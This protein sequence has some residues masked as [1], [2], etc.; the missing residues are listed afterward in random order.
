MMADYLMPVVWSTS[1]GR[2]FEDVQG[3]D[4]DNFILVTEVDL[5]YCM[6]IKSN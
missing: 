1:F 3:F 4:L 2:I 6:S 5:I